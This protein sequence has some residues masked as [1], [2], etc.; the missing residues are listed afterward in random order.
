MAE[1]IPDAV[2]RMAAFEHVRGLRD[3]Q[4][5]LTSAQLATEADKQSSP[6]MRS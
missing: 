5:E 1:S 3:A 4:G 2:I 6:A